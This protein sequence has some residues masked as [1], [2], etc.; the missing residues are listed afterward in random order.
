M[1]DSSFE[2]RDGPCLSMWQVDRAA[3]ACQLCESGDAGIVGSTL[4]VAG[5]AFSVNSVR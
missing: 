3:M 1:A 2:R 4:N 5:P